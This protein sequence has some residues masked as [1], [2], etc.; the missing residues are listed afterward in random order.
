MNPK[1]DGKHEVKSKLSFNRWLVAYTLIKNPQL[2]ELR[3]HCIAAKKTDDA[4]DQMVM[5]EDDRTFNNETNI[6][7]E[8]VIDEK[9]SRLT[10]TV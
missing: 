5:A 2:Q 7:D 4:V 1:G 6:N 10:T 8:T 9:E 3:A